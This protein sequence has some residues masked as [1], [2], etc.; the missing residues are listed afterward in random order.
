M[1]EEKLD[2]FGMPHPDCCL[3]GITAHTW[4]L[5]INVCVMAKKHFNHFLEMR[6]M[7]RRSGEGVPERYVRAILDQQLDYLPIATCRGAL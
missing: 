7:R 2:A 6:A 4:A 5:G 1:L 3:Q